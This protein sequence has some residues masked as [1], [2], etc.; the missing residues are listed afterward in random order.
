MLGQGQRGSEK[1][2]GLKR[3]RMLEVAEERRAGFGSK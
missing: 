3:W 2:L 1:G